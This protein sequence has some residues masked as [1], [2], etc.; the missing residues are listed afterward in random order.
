MGADDGSLQRHPRR[1]GVGEV[2]RRTGEQLGV[3]VRPESGDGIAAGSLPHR[4]P[5]VGGWRPGDIPA[6]APTQAAGPSQ[7]DRLPDGRGVV[8]VETREHRIRR[9]GGQGS[10]RHGRQRGDQQHDAEIGVGWRCSAGSGNR[11]QDR[12]A[13][14]PAAG[15]S[16]LRP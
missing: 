2:G 4:G 16:Q 1:H 5:D 7:R 6:I 12:F 3:A 14:R 11:C 15:L 8:G 13:E 10:I 9:R